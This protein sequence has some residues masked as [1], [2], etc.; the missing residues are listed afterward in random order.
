M[1]TTSNRIGW[2]VVLFVCG[3]GTG[4][5]ASARLAHAEGP[6][7]AERVA[8]LV[9]RFG[10]KKVELVDPE[11]FG[12]AVATACKG[13]RECAARLVTMAIA[14]SGLSAAVSR[15]EYLPHQGDAYTDRNGVR[16]HRAWGTYQQ[17]KSRNN[18]DVWGSS[19]HLIQAESA[20]RMQLGALA[21]CR[22]FRGVQPEI[23]MWRVLSGRGCTLPYSGE[24]KR[25]QILAQVRRAL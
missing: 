21:E 13:E 12:T 10:S 20:R 1:T 7:M 22:K 6:T 3:L 19:D 8:K 23:G 11:E 9:P 5:C 24:E 18:A 15:S 17:H 16:V 25:M 14:E 4:M 2:C